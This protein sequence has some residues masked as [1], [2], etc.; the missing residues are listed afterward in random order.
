MSSQS[1]ARYLIAIALCA[2]LLETTSAQERASQPPTAQSQ[3]AGVYETERRRALELLQ[4]NRIPEALQVLE[5]LALAQPSDGEVQFYL[6]FARLANARTL[7]DQEARRQARLQARAALL[8]AKQLGVKN[9]LLE[10]LIEIIPPDGSEPVTKF[11]ENKEADAAMHEGEDAFVKGDLDGAL[12]AYERAFKLDPKLYE[13]AL[14][15]GDMHYRKKTWD[16]AAEWFG[17]AIAIDPD[18][19]TAYRYWGDALMAQGK[20]DEARDKFIEAIVAEPYNRATWGALIQWAEEAQ[21]QLG[22]P[23]VEPANESVKYWKAYK[24]TRAAWAKS[25]FAKEFPNEKAYRHS[26]REEA[27]ALRAA[28]E[29]AIRDPELG[30]SAAADPTLA[31]LLNLYKADLIEAYVLLARADEGIARDYAGYRQTNRDKLRQYIREQ[32]IRTKR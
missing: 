1:L 24:D 4:N 28:A 22:H 7:P 12:A 31:N 13:A 16:K 15:A 29:V 2:V 8:R 18:R 11:S 10:Q 9:D 32:V 17:R 23:R 3:S 5:K 14:F 25:E 6:G 19:E 26:L 30:K 21:A 27:A 20:L